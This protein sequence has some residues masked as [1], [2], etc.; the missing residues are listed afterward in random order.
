M[1]EASAYRGARGYCLEVIGHADYACEND[2]VCAAVSALI[3]ALAAYLEQND[4]DCTSDAD[5]ADGYAM[6]TLC[7]RNAA[8]DMVV[9]GLEAI[10]DQ[11]PHYVTTRISI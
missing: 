6:V 4:T 2:V 10:A 7:E 11:Y 5:L 3:E 8:F 1:I 9:C